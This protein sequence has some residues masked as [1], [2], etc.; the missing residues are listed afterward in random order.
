MRPDDFHGR[1]GAMEWSL[2]RRERML[3]GVTMACVGHLYSVQQV[4]EGDR[5]NRDIVLVLSPLT[6]EPWQRLTGASWAIAVSPRSD[7]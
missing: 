3:P 5:R 6:A 4:G 7:R 2:R 1:R